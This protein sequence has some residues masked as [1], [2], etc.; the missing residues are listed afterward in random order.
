MLPLIKQK[1]WINII[2]FLFIAA[3][4]FLAVRIGNIQLAD[5]DKFTQLARSQ[6]CKRI[7]LPA[8]RGSILDRNGKVLAESLLV[9]SVSADPSEIEDVATTAYHLGNIL[10][11]EQSRLIRLLNRKRRFVWIKRKVSDEELDAITKLS[12]KGIYINHEF[13]RFY[14]NQQLGSHILG[15]TDIDDNGIEGVELTFNEV[16]SGEPGYKFIYRDAL[17]RHIITSNSKIQLP[18]HGNN[19]VLTIDATIQRMTEEELGFAYEKWMPASATA[20]VMDV[21]TG[22]VLAMANYPTYDPNHFQ[23]YKPGDRKNLAVTDSYEP[24]SIMKPIVLS[25]IIEHRVAKPDDKVFCHNG[26]Y[27][28]GRRTLRDTHGGHGNLTVSEI[29]T[30]SSNIG[31]AKLS[32]LIGKQKMYQ[33]LKQFEFGKRT[34][35]ELPGEASGIFRPGRLWSE[36][37]T[38]VSVSMGYEISVTPLQFITAFCSI[39]NGGV[40]VKPKIVKSRVSNDDKIVE[41]FQSQQIVRRVMSGNVARDIMN[42]ILTMAVTRGTGKRANLLE[43]DVAGKTGTSRKTSGSGKQYSREKYL[44]SFIAYAP[45]DRPRICVLV[46]INEPQGDSYYGGTVAAPVV[47]EILRRSLI[48]LGVEPQKFKMAMQ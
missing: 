41:E 17:Q 1:F 31:M 40:L 29:L 22:E 20:I 46:M 38:L 5:Y 48:Y 10:K 45:A 43:Y 44:G 36:T 30:Y 13:H 15:F 25:G 24:G 35:I 16:L 2:G 21:M 18:R 8:R 47:R 33:Y 4:I 37:Y 11:I 28:I 23:K 7:I 42:P 39:P 19:V 3:F 14:P 34:G 32:M 26:V 27:K 12:L 6:Q 9:G